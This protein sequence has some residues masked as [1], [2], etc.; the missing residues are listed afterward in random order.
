MART[1]REPE[2]H[3]L[4]VC[5]EGDEVIYVGRSIHPAK[6]LHE[7][8]K[9]VDGRIGYHIKK[10]MPA[11][12]SW[13]V[14]FLAAEECEPII[15]EYCHFNYKSYWI[16]KCDPSTFNQAIDI[17]EQALIRYYRPLCNKTYKKR[18]DGPEDEDE[19]PRITAYYQ[20]LYLD[21]N[22]VDYIEI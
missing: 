10:H 3:N 15:M 21:D 5:R 22:A 16:H 2:E 17:A 7:H 8:I 1:H 6:R 19:D 11:S 9:G 14:E 18:L 20:K 13:T 4:Y 12:L